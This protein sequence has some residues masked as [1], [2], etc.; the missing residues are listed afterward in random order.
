MVQCCDGGAARVAFRQGG[1]C[2]WSL[3]WGVL[4]KGG[5]CEGTGPCPV[6]DIREDLTAV[7]DEP[8]PSLERQRVTC[9]HTL[10]VCWPG[11]SVILCGSFSGKGAG[12]GAG[13]LGSEVRL[14][15][16]E[17]ESVLSTGGRR[18]CGGS[19]GTPGGRLLG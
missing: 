3:G 18:V 2:R 11:T 8:S 7:N 17:R 15:E 6:A 14:W 12:A 10:S 16:G 4:E 9:F 5:L 13:G 1:Q 19:L